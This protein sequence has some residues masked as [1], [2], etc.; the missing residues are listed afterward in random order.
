MKGD[1]EIVGTLRGFDDYVNMVI[2]D[3]KEYTFT[4]QGKKITELDSILLNGNNITMMVPGGDPEEN[5]G[6][7]GAAM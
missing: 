7:G 4:P 3:V 6:K 5:E 1:K 2:D